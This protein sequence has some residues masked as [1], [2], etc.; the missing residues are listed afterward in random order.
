[1]INW[2]CLRVARVTIAALVL[3]VLGL[4]AAIAAGVAGAAREGH[5]TSP[6]ASIAGSARVPLTVAKAS[7]ALHGGRLTGSALIRN[8]TGGSVVAT[9]NAWAWRSS[10]G[11]AVVG[12]KTFFV[13]RIGPHRSTNIKFQAS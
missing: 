11:G 5:G 13:S 7:V 1:M 6:T 12:L 2:L 10:R 8:A 9:E 4:G 3:L